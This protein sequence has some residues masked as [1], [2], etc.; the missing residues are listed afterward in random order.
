MQLVEEN[1]KNNALE[2]IFKLPNDCSYEDIMYSLYVKS[3]VEAGLNDIKNGNYYTHEEVEKM[4]LDNHRVI[5]C[6]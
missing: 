3:K 5:E 4:F 6:L 1:I 2:L